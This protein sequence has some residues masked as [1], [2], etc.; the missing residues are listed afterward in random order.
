MACAPHRVVPAHHSR[1][2]LEAP[3]RLAARR[4]E[5]GAFGVAQLERRAIVDGRAAERLLAF[6]TAVE[7]FG[8]LVGG[9]ELACPLERLGRLTVKRHPLR[10]P[11]FQV[12]DDSEPGEVGL[13][14]ISIFAPRSFE[15]GV[16][17][18]QD[19]ATGRSRGEQPIDQRGARV[20]DV[21]EPG[22][23]G[24]EADGGNGGHA[25]S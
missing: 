21:N 9:I 20:A 10:L 15:V 13:D 5:R 6:A 11:A 7:L 16:V 3:V 2:E 19:E 12:G 14:R 24:G 4:L 23:R 18:A 25:P 22:R 17:E 8:R 1:V